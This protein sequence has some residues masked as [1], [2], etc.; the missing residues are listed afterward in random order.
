LVHT[1]L[2]EGRSSAFFTILS[3]N[4]PEFYPFIECVLRSW[5]EFPIELSGENNRTENINYSVLHRHFVSIAPIEI[6]QGDEGF[7]ML[8]QIILLDSSSEQQ[9][10]SFICDLEK[11]DDSIYE[12]ID[13]LVYFDEVSFLFK[14]RCTNLIK[15]IEILINTEDKESWKKK[16]PLGDS[17]FVHS[18]KHELL[19]LR[20][21]LRHISCSLQSI[22][23]H[24]SAFNSEHYAIIKK[25]W[26]LLDDLNESK[27]DPSENFIPVIRFLLNII[28]DDKVSTKPTA[29]AFS[30]M[31]YL[32]NTM[33]VIENGLYDD[34]FALIST[35][36]ALSDE[37]IKIPDEISHWKRLKSSN[38]DKF[39][40]NHTK[41]KIKAK[42]H[43]YR[44]EVVY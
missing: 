33:D 24:Y 44:F 27:P 37:K 15:Q 12:S 17:L 41:M 3:A 43:S 11:I 26:G 1:H 13:S 6:R 16:I 35:L 14:D 34:T 38:I 31:L 40:D 21:Y 42:C 23:Q 25:V 28:L 32:L 36:E 18:G 2:N 20:E 9:T 39:L 30:G 4:N 22:Q 8:S 29:I 19:L 10:N 5:C 7:P